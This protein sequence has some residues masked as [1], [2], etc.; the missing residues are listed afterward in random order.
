M[1]PLKKVQ[2]YKNRSENV[3]ATSNNMTYTF[4]E[5]KMP[6]LAAFLFFNFD[7]VYIRMYLKY[8]QVFELVSFVVLL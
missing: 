2:V 1:P 3:E 4:F 6:N 5:K 8:F 7:I